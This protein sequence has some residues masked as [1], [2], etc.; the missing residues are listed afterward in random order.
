MS[1]NP[2]IAAASPR[3]VKIAGKEWFISPL[4]QEEW[5]EYMAWIQDEWLAV[6]KR[7]A[8][9]LEPEDRTAVLKQAFDQA[10]RMTLQ[11]IQSQTITESPSGI[12][13]LV[14]MHL[15]RRHPDITPEKVAEL[16]NDS[17]LLADAMAAVERA[18]EGGLEK[19]TVHRP[20]RT[21]RRKARKTERKNASAG[22]SSRR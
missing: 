7:N 14:W 6:H 17:Q 8:A 11:S 15:R 12:F 2:Q 10:G 21:A 19:K 18:N 22:R 13:R 9:D 20:K 16:L 1:T 3:V 4:T 5:A